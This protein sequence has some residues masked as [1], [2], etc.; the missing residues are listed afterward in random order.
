M[1]EDDNANRDMF[2]YW[3][4]MMCGQSIEFPYGGLWTIKFSLKRLAK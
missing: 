1:S 4:V 3:N 2:I